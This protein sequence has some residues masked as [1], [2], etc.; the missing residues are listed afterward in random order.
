MYENNICF[1]IDYLICIANL[2]G[3]TLL[4]NKNVEFCKYPT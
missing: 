3:F 2:K 1:L 4:L